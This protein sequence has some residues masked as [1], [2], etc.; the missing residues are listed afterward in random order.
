[1]GQVWTIAT[2]IEDQRVL[3]AISRATAMLEFSMDGVILAAND[4]YLRILGKPLDQVLGRQRGT[5]LHPDDVDP[6]ARDRFWE[7]LRAGGSVHGEFRCLSIDFQEI[8]LRTSFAP[9]FGPGGQPVSVVEV[10][11]DIT[12]ERRHADNHRHMLEAISRST[13]MIEFALDGTVL[14]ANPAYLAIMG[15]SEAEIRGR[16]HRIFLSANDFVQSDYDGFWRRL[17]SGEFVQSEFH[18]LGKGGRSVWLQASYNPVLGPDGTPTRIMKIATDITEAVER[19]HEMA[20]L[21]FVDALTSLGNRR[22]FDVELASTV[23][24]C[25]RDASDLAL[26]MIDIDHFKIFNDTYG[27]HEGDVCLRAV[28]ATIRQSF[29]RASDLVMRFGG[30]E[31]A[32]LLAGMRPHAVRDAAER[33]RLQI[34]RLQIENRRTPLGVVTASVGSAILGPNALSSEAAATKLLTQADRALY[35][36]KSLGRNQAYAAPA[37]QAKRTEQAGPHAGR[38]SRIPQPRA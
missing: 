26:V 28:A 9:V 16:S 2:S 5:L 25:K 3:D 1:M 10:A 15:Y 35:R 14:F 27:H 8:W 20:R 36:A 38:Q 17:R 21:A 31:F 30:E 7:T 4:C 29:R 22:K 19:R 24:Q 23:A 34:E 18:R 13:A 11:T 32:V 6:A 33:C 12:G 37:T